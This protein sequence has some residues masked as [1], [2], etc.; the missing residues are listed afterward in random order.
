MNDF[1]GDNINVTSGA[2]TEREK[3][4]KLVKRVFGLGALLLL[5]LVVIVALFKAVYT[6]DEGERG[7]IT[8]NGKVVGTAEPGLSLK[9]PYIDEVHYISLRSFAYN[10]A[11]KMSSYSSDLQTVT[12]DIS[13]NYHINPASVEQVYKQ[14][15]TSDNM[16]SQLATQ[17]IPAAVKDVFGLF[18]APQLIQKRTAVSADI[19]QHL[20]KE[21]GSMLVLEGVNLK[22]VEFERSYEEKIEA[23]QKEEV[24]IKQRGFTK[25]KEMVNNDIQRNKA[26]AEAYA[27]RTEADAEAYAT[28]KRGEAEAAAT[29]AVQE[30]LSSSPNYI[31][32]LFAKQWKGILPTTMVPG[33]AVPFMPLN[34]LYPQPAAK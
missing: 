3:A 9:W 26:D 24:E 32:Y 25:Q 10:P 31:Q 8:R 12:I 13:I 20:S 30:A 11:G 15:R 5:S 33:Q 23:T 4:V 17:K 34:T 21:L 16:V 18:T 19:T 27:K 29:K 7:V 22:D 2:A 28:M 1:R 6:V 14:Y